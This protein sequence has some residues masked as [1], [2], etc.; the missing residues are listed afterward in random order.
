MKTIQSKF[1]LRDDL[2]IVLVLKSHANTIK[3][4]T[5]KDVILWYK[6]VHEDIIVNFLD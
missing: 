1:Q 2:Q 5:N 3:T 4:K 6:I